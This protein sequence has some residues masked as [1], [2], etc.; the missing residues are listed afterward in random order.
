[1]FLLEGGRFNVTWNAE[2]A[3]LTS[4]EVAENAEVEFNISD[5]ASL[6]VTN[7]TYGAG[8]VV[9]KTGAGEF[10]LGKNPVASLVQQAGI[11]TISRIGVL[12]ASFTMNA[13]TLRVEKQ[14]L[15]LE[16]RSFPSGYTLDVRAPGLRVDSPVSYSDLAITLGD[17]LSAGGVYALQSDDAAFLSYAKSAIEASGD[18]EARI[19]GDGIKV[20]YV[21]DN[22][23]DA[24]A[25]SDLSDV[26]AWKGGRVP[27]GEDVIIS[28]AGMAQLTASS[29]SFRTVAVQN[30]A[31]LSVS[32][33]TLEEP[34]DLPPV[35][36]AY[37][38]R[39]LVEGG[40]FAQSTNGIDCVATAV[41]LPVL[42]VATNA[43]LTL[44]TPGL[45]KA[46]TA[47]LSGTGSGNA[48][49]GFRLYNVNLKWY[50]QIRMTTE[51][52]DTEKVYR[53][54][55]GL[56]GWAAAGDTTYI[57]LDCQ[58][59]TLYRIDTYNTQT[60]NYTPLM[61]VYP[62]VG[63]TVIPVGTLLLRDY[64]REGEGQYVG[65]GTQFGVNSP[66]S[67]RIPVLVDGNTLL[68]GDGYNKVAGG[69]DV[70]L[71]GPARWE[72]EHDFANDHN[73][74][75]L[76][77]LLGTGTLTLED[78]GYLG[79]TPTCADIS[80]CGIHNLGT[81]DDAV[82]LCAKDSYVGFWEWIGNGKTIAHI[83]D[84]YI[85][86]GQLYRVSA[87]QGIDSRWRQM[88]LFEGFKSIE[89]PEGKTMWVTAT[90]IW[91]GATH[92]DLVHDWDRVT[93]FGPPITGGGNVS[94][95][96]ALKGTQAKYSMTAIITNSEN[97]ATGLATAEPPSPAGAKSYLLFADGA[98]WAGTVVA[99][100]RVGL[101]N[102]T[103][104]AAAPV[105]VTFGTLL[106]ETN[107]PVRLWKSEGVTTNDV[108]N[109]TGGVSGGYGLEPEFMDGYE[110]QI[111][112]TFMLG[113]YP[114]NV[115]LPKLAAGHKWRL[116]TEERGEETVLV[117][118]YQ[119]R[120]FTFTVK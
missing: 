17:E 76:M 73:Y 93:K 10:V 41:H 106:F 54:S 90:N 11:V 48:D 20:V 39:L 110:P 86:V 51:Q 120:G 34:V 98:N 82:S 14:D 35:S 75:R 72:Y 15:T 49:Y 55:Q 8:S 56:I 100:G 65:S 31:T 29:P 6:T 119:P 24:S 67:V 26:T 43:T 58:G 87:S 116:Y 9:T 112:D 45:P 68:K 30:G 117:L 104:E 77:Q 81:M 36:L 47:S 91:R 52:T 115:A 16:G 83:E 70:T 57:G 89:V 99:N 103:A 21:P 27:E 19:E 46:V 71:R 22:T 61:I 66:A 114:A 28:G 96:N 111:G 95:T 42:E 38:A 1:M 25:S 37:D 3:N 13:G 101:T 109:I 84:S 63:G 113:A 88:P 105:S 108:I 78:G 7:A 18:Y 33:G 5:G 2:F 44:Q 102:L 4:F 92:W 32:G 62:D 64:R 118:R 80:Y 107:F 12:P 53:M 79:I 60:C 85:M 50:G 94:V 59:G 97:T 74:R 40:A 23:F 69:A